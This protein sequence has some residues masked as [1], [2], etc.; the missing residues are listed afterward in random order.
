MNVLEKH[1]GSHRISLPDTYTPE[2]RQFVYLQVIKNII[3]QIPHFNS[4]QPLLDY[5]VEAL[6]N[7]LN[8][9]IASIFSYNMSQEIAILLAQNGHNPQPAP[10]GYTQ[11]IYSGLLGRTLRSGHSFLV[12][13]VSK[14]TDYVAP[15][16][17]DPACSELCVPIY[18]HNSLWGA[19]NIESL[20]V[21]K[22]SHYDRLALELIASQLGSAIYSLELR[23]EQRTILEDLEVHVKHQQ[24]LLD[25]ISNLATPVFSVSPGILALPLMGN[26]D[27][28]RMQ[29]ILD[30]LIETLQETQ[31]SSVILDVSGKVIDDAVINMLKELKN[32]SNLFDAEI[33]V[34]GIQPE[35]TQTL[36]TLQSDIG[37][38]HVCQNFV[39]GLQQALHISGNSIPPLSTP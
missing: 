37:I 28:S 35:E 18:S 16:G 36:A 11:S 8:F 5:V 24:H 22:F 26:L 10:I 21:G 38:S 13:D 2:P 19:F 34:T 7:Q 25:H 4:M 30:T 1:V 31:S 33:I 15:Q 29:Q 32:G 3:Q 17:Y 6:Q 12:D 27:T 39:A 20:D 23:H 14:L 9:Y